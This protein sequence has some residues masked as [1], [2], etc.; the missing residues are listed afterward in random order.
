[1]ATPITVRE[2]RNT[3]SKPVKPQFVSP[4]IFN[5]ATSNIR[6]FLK[7]YERCAAA[8]A[9]QNEHKILFFGSFLEGVANGWYEGFVADPA[10][11]NKT[12]EEIKAASIEEFEIENND[13]ALR[14]KLRNRKQAVT[15]SIV[16][17]FYEILALCHE[18]N[19]NMP[20]EDIKEHFE[21]GLHPDFFNNYSLL[22]IQATDMRSLKEIIAKLNTINIAHERYDLTEMRNAL[23]V[24]TLAAPKTL[25]NSTKPT[26]RQNYKNQQHRRTYN[27]GPTCYYCNTRG[28]IKRNCQLFLA[29]RPEHRNNETR[30]Y[31][32]AR[33][34]NDRRDNSET[35]GYNTARSYSG[36]RENN[37]TRE[38]SKSPM[39]NVRFEQASTSGNAPRRA[40]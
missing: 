4:T 6:N 8:N 1:M 38:R 7:T 11:A 9:W 23:P 39:R 27:K 15:E 17:F 18:I 24:A 19:P 13:K 36:I 30:G 12:W 34:Y 32:T 40:Q 10:N 5:P 25:Q 21:D 22:S 33:G 35:R 2:A 16:T 29:N 14:I 20:F 28:H 37:A 3:G 26:Q 31:N